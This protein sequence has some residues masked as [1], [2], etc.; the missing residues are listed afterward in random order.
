VHDELYEILVSNIY[1]AGAGMLPWPKAFAPLL[2]A[3]DLWGIQL[4]GVDKKAGTLLFSHDTGDNPAAFLDYLRTYHQINPRIGPSLSLTVDEWMH[5]HEHFDDAYVEKSPFYQDFVIP[6]GSR[7]LSGTKII[8]DEET[9]VL[10]GAM[11]ALGKQPLLAADV[12]YLNRVKRHLVAAMKIYLHLRKAQADAGVGRQLLDQFQYP[13]LLVDGQRSIRFRNKVAAETLE[14][15]DFIVE[16][17]GSLGCRDPE[18]DHQLTLALRTLNLAD[19]TP[20][21]QVTQRAFVRVRRSSG[22]SIALYL[23]A[24]RPSVTMGAFA[25]TPIALLIFHDPAQR[26]SLDPFI[27]AETFGLSP[28]E[29]RVSIA[30][31]NGLRPKEISRSSGISINTI[32]TQIKSIHAKT[33]TN[34]R[35]DLIRV[36]T[37]IGTV[38][39]IR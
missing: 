34:Q 11:R 28:A 39:G 6:H 21:S 3:L 27:L 13:M 36:L 5:D 35:G 29:A 22:S 20:E 38:V 18:S 1:S 26:A 25:Q 8:E 9:L 14:S 30:L 7:Y 33:G 16:R 2:E 17:N 31:A 23:T 32:Q 15:T 37:N 4:L 12:E 19:L 10:F 24:L